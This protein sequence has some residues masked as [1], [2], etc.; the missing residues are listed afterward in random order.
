MR[1]FFAGVGPVDILVNNAGGV[2][3]QVGHPLEEVSDDDWH[4]VVNANLTTRVPL[5]PGG[6]AGH[7][8]ARLGPDRQHRLG[9]RA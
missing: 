3:G 9:R 7:E 5:H 8:G 1:E 6:R 4:A 2:C